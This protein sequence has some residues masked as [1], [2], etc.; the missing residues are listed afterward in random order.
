MTTDELSQAR[1]LAESA[2]RSHESGRMGPDK[3]WCGEHDSY[4]SWPCE[5]AWLAVNLL[6]ALE[7]IEEYKAK[8]AA[9]DELRKGAVVAVGLIRKGS[10]SVLPSMMDAL[11]A[12]HAASTDEVAEQ[13][14]VDE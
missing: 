6:A 5:S 1:E 12:R 13:R 9:W 8:A 11:L 14:G 7:E 2:I 4:A 3:L 10:L